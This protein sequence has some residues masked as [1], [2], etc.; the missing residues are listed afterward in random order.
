[1]KGYWQMDEESAKALPGEGWFLS[2]DAAY[3]EDGYLFIHDRVKDMIISGGENVYPAEI[4]NALMAHP[5]IA[6][7]AVVGVPDDKWGEVGKA[8]VVAAPDTEITE[9]EIIAFAKERLAG[10][11]CP[12]SVNFVEVLP[13]NPSGKILKRELR[14]PFWEGLDRQV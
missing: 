7:V 6:D 2:G 12:Q 8:M 11:K 3:M 1:M 5:G 10:F 14:A 13:R 9:E 4:E